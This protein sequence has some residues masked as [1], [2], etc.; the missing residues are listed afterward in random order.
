MDVLE[1]KNRNEDVLEIKMLLKQSSKNELIVYVFFK[2]LQKAIIL[3]REI[4]FHATR[5]A[6]A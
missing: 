1:I 6:L 2:T 3:C 5:N 4:L